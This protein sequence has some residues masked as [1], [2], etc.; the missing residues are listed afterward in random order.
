MTHL[1]RPGRFMTSA[2]LF[3]IDWSSFPVFTSS[4]LMLSFKILPD[5]FIFDD[6]GIKSNPIIHNDTLNFF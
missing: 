1:H 4:I 6:S 2:A 3:F 5:S